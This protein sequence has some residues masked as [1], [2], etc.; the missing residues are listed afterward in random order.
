VVEPSRLAVLPVFSELEQEELD[1]IA[2]YVDSV[3]VPAGER[4]VSGG[5]FAY[6]FFI[7]ETGTAEVRVEEEV[8]AELAPGDFFGELGLLVTGRRTAD[9]VASSPMTLVAMFDQN[10]R[11]LERNQPPF[12]DRIR[13]VLLERMSHC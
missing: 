8:V 12:S 13:S 4:V 11:R 9:V 7:V 6:E 10:F 3:D 1:A 2:K 5:D